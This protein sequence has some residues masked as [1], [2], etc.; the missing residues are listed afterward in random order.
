[1]IVMGQDALAGRYRVESRIAAGGMGEVWRARDLILD[2][3]VAVKVLKAEHV[4]DADFRARFRAEAQ[5]AAGLSHPGIASVYDYGERDGPDGRSAWLVMELVAGEPLSERLR[6]GPLDVPTTLDVIAQTAFALQAAHDGGVV[7]RDVK[8]GNLLLRPDGVVKVT[9]FGI[10]YAAG[11]TPLTRTGTVVGTAYYL[12]PEQARGEAVTGASDIYSLGV[13]A[14]ECL[15]GRRPFPG[16]NPIA[17]SRAHLYEPPPALPDHIPAGVRALISAALDKAPNGRPASAGAM[18]RAAAALQEAPGDAALAA[19]AVGERAG[20]RVLAAAAGPAASR[21]RRAG[22]LAAALLTVVALAFG[23]R[24]CLAPSPTV[25]PQLL[26]GGT[27]QPAEN[28]VRAAGLAAR[29]RTVP[30]AA[31]AAGA[32]VGSDPA[33]GT[34]VHRGD[35]VTLLVSEGPTAGPAVASPQASTPSGDS[36]SGSDSGKGGGKGNGKDGREK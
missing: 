4:D 28:A 5:H 14:F 2:R 20:T 32:L 12:S 24:A 8:P 27:I 31:I 25:V 30:S 21:H 19:V 3:P 23:A 15:T 13:V 16:D 18:A 26:A 22:Q 35:Q 34:A 36:G 1:M 7:H 10:A 17:I 33:A 11:A 6:R 29:R 9:D